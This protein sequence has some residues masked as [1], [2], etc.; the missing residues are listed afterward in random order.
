MY[1]CSMWH[2]NVPSILRKHGMYAV[3]H[4]RD[5]KKA[6]NKEAIRQQVPNKR[7]SWT[8]F[9]KANKIS[10]ADTK[11]HHLCVLIAILNQKIS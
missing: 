5:V 11:G 9:N 10:K 6:A 8:T 7:P 4:N 2:Y 3:V 1:N